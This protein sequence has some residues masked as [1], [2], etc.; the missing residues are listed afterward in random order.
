VP[1]HLTSTA[2]GEGGF[3]RQIY[4]VSTMY[5]PRTRLESLGLKRGLPMIF[6]HTPKCGGSFVAD[7]IG[8]RRERHC[9][10]RRHPMLRGHKTYL[11][12]QHAFTTLGIDINKFVTFS[13]VRCIGSGVLRLM[14]LQPE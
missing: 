4:G 9:F 2:F 8:H 7:A 13:V 11:E 12:Y 6:V 3:V 5:V 1:R 14:R 10:T